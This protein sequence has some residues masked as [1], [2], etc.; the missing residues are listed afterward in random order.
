MVPSLRRLLARFIAVFRSKRADADLSREIESHLQLLEDKFMAEGMSAKEARRVA[1][2][3]FG[4]VQQVKEHQR[5]ERSLGWLTNWTLDA[6]LGLRMLVKHPGLSLVSVIG[7]ALAITIATGYFAVFGMFLD[8]PL[9]LEEGDRMIAIQSRTMAGP[10]AGDT[11]DATALDYLY[12]R[13]QLKTISELGAFKDETRNLLIDGRH[14]ESITVAEITASG[15][16]MARVAPM[17]GR[18]L[19]P[20][21]E[22]P[23][24][25]PVLVI[26]Y[27][28]WHRVFGE[29]REVLGRTVRLDD[30][31]YTIVGVMPKRFGYPVHHQYWTPLHLTSIAAAAENTD[32]LRVI[33]RL[34][35]GATMTTARAELAAI[36]DR[37][38]AAFPQ[39]HAHVRPQIL[40]YTRAFVGIES[41]EMELGIRAVQLGVGL[42]LLIVAANVAV[43]IYARTATR[44]GEIAVRTALGARRT[45]IVAQFFIEA[46]V[47]SGTAGIIALVVLRIALS[48]ARAYHATSTDPSDRLPF[49]IDGLHFSAGV[50]VYVAALAI[51]AAVIIGALPALKATGR[52]VQNTLQHFSAR[53]AG[54]RLGR[55]WTVL[56]ILQVMIA[57]AAMPVAMHIAQK[58]TRAGIRKVSPSAAALIQGRLTTSREGA[59]PADALPKLIERLKQEREVV[60][61]SFAQSFPGRENG[62]DFDLAEAE[63]VPHK[64]VVLRTASDRISSELF[65][66]LD[67]PLLAGRRFTVAD[68][69]TG[70]NTVVV[71]QVFADRMGGGN[72][73][74]RRIRY[75]N[76]SGDQTKW[77]E[78]YEI[79]GVVPAFASSLTVQNDFSPTLPRVFQAAAP[80]TLKNVTLIVRINGS[81][82][83]FV[84]KLI[85]I[86]AS[87]D[88]TLRLERLEPVGQTWEHDQRAIAMVALVVIA[89]VFSVLLLSAAGIYAMMSF[90]LASRRHEIG[91]RTALGADARHLLLGIFGRAGA[92][93][94]VGVL[95]GMAVAVGFDWA[96]PGGLMGERAIVFLPGVAI[97]MFTVGLFAAIGPARRSLA[98]EPAEALRDE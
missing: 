82:A 72:V 8:T 42:L 63:L 92:Q 28:E 88:P 34:A 23:G 43:L 11:S 31:T 37:M 95:V 81:G 16:N 17:L 32:R 25:P 14:A 90:I 50:F 21:D 45:R 73:V 60:A 65:S 40:A 2:V 54:V 36:G 61:V 53:A 66:V 26:G 89:L 69:R 74:G 46:L 20:E 87:V 78:W 38:A 97:V 3:A 91:I 41:P 10:D 80:E 22:R 15:F 51:V 75:S 19:L 67:V 86:T 35:D 83:A 59:K 77:S 4:G 49:W 33:G 13:E 27:D 18:P 93:L 70:A 71:D 48:V 7:M 58:S 30:T 12:W 24:A 76:S 57:V 29:D 56:I 96:V 9:P 64:T 94:G 98:I 6:K 79:V 47:L 1:R 39:R 85:D 5:E 62:G 44:L 68:E 84:P 52:S 55:T